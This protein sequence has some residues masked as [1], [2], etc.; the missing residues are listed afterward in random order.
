MLIFFAYTPFFERVFQAMIN[1]VEMSFIQK[2]F[3]KGKLQD[4]AP[5]QMKMVVGTLET[6]IE[7]T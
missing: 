7:K 1:A 4:F 3:A 6:E 2:I 5:N